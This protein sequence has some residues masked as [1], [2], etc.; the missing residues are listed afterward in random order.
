MKLR[1]ISVLL[2]LV[3]LGPSVCHA[4]ANKTGGNYEVLLDSANTRGGQSEGGGYAVLSS[5]GQRFS[6]GGVSASTYTLVSGLMGAVDTTPPTIAITSPLAAAA[7]SGTISMIGT[8]FDQN[9]IEWTL[10]VGGGAAPASWEKLAE[11]AGNR[12]AAYTFGNWDSAR[13]SGDY[14]FRL[15]AVDSRGNTAEGTV[16][17]DVAYTFTITGTIPAFKWIFMG[18]PVGVNSTD[19]LTLFG[20]TAEYKVYKWDPAAESREYVDRYRYPTVLSAGDGFWIRAFH[21]DLQYSYPGSPV[22]TNRNYTI[23]LKK[24]WNMI[25]SPFNNVFPWDSAQVTRGAA[26][27]DLGSA[28]TALLID[29]IYYTYDSDG[30]VWVQNGSGTLMRPQ[31][32][33]YVYAYEDINLVFDPANRNF[34]ARMTARQMVDYRI[35]ISA[36]ARESKDIYNYFGS[37]SFT[38][39]E[40]DRYDSPEP[41]MSPDAL[42]GKRTA[43]YFPRDEWKK[44][45]GRYT[46]DM[47]PLAPIG[48][49]ESWAF[50]VDTNEIG[51][52]VE[53]R[54]DNGSLPADRFGFTLTNLDSGE[55]VDMAARDVYTYQAAGDGNS[56]ARFRIDAVK[57]DVGTIKLA[58]KL[59]KG[60]NLVSIPLSLH[61]SGAE[62]Q[63]GNNLKKMEVVRL[64]AR[65]YYCAREEEGVD[66]Q[67]GTAYWMYTGEEKE[68]EFHGIAVDG[69]SAVDV[70]LEAGFNMIGSPFE[71]GMV[72]G[73][74]IA[75]EAGEAGMPLSEAVKSGVLSGVIYRYD[76]LAGAYVETKAGENMEPWEGYFIKANKVCTLKLKK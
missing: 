70:T 25:S 17:F 33:G 58:R 7:A 44:N 72:F 62:S 5:V 41:P 32:G 40:F 4:G 18:V 68:I 45:P 48:A 49:T 31:V 15:V 63:L 2:L 52:T 22:E 50:N 75:V 24:G 29:S 13:Y 73:D 64:Q 54:W 53:L 20:A 28:A 55:S 9:D 61:E 1:I 30:K 39:E 57:L 74:N 36:T 59:K 42:E 35:K 10:Y 3:T 71:T 46:N 56:S 16:T 27:Y 60:W 66:L 69:A 6:N 43:L 76:T 26:T 19:P 8:A 14:T 38:D 67:A 65:K 51:E 47:R 12:V 21:Q 37:A 23:A 34:S 11:G